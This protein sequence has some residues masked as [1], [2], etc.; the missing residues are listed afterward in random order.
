MTIQIN[1]TSGISGVDGS[2]A[3]P[4]LQGS[5]SNTGISFGTDEVNINTG[6]TT[7][8]TVDSSGR[9]LVGTSTSIGQDATTQIRND[10]NGYA[11]STQRSTDG[12]FPVRFL[13]ERSRG[14]VGTPTALQDNDQIWEARF[15]GY[16]GSEYTN[17]SMIAAEV[18][19][20][21]SDVNNSVPGR[22]VFSTTADGAS[23]PTSRIIINAAGTLY[24]AAD[25]SYQAGSS[26]YRWTAIYAVNGTIQTSDARE[27]TFVEQSS[28][29]SDFIRALNPVSYKWKV[30]GNIVSKDEN[31]EDIITPVEGQRTHWGFIAQEVK[32]AADAAG[33]DFG[34]WILT[35]KDDPES[36]QGLRY[37]Q[38]I[39]PLT[40]ALQ[41]ALE[42]IETL[43][44]ANASQAA[45]IAA[46][47]A[48]LT[49]LEGGTNP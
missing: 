11:I 8:A 7:R 2:A 44:T 39:A 26:G 33:V 37:D 30:G 29:G 28:L 36:Q 41:E 10:S 19:G 14:S 38:F 42:R 43:E 22:L 24:P 21:V 16:D 35:D 25:N 1:G 15:Y 12:T 46:L 48:R 17:S 20:T 31:N 49:A 18:D 32:E 40:K 27:K 9:L 13:A 6:G 4:A 45:T 5:D 34:G 47:D 23:S 3:T